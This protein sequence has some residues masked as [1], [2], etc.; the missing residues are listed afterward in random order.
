MRTP[1]TGSASSGAA[2]GQILSRRRV[3]EHVERADPD[4]RIGIGEARTGEAEIGRIE[5][6]RELGEQ[7]GAVETRRRRIGCRR[8]EQGAG[9]GALA[10]GVVEG[11][12]VVLEALAVGSVPAL[13]RLCRPFRRLVLVTVVAGVR[14]SEP[15]GEIGPRNAQRVV[16]ARVDDHVGAGRHVA[17]GAADGRIDA[18]VP[19]VRGDSVFLRRVALQTDAVAGEFQP[20][21]VRIVAVAAG[22]ALGEHLA[23]L[24]RAVIVDFI[25]HLPVGEIEAAGERRDDMRVRQPLAGDPILRDRPAAGVAEAAGLDLLAQDRRRR[26]APGVA[27]RSVDRPAG[28]LALVEIDD[29]AF[30]VAGLV[31]RAPA[32]MGVRPGDMR[33]ALAVAGLAADADL[34]PCGGEGVLC[35]VVVLAHAGRVAFGAHEVPVLVEP[36]PV[37]DVVMA[38]RLVRIERKPALPA[39]VLRPAVPGDGERLQAPIGKSDQ[40][41]L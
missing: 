32:G 18:R 40:I 8:R 35:R 38:D 29:Q 6:G 22:D 9:A 30:G 3:F 31:V 4:H 12:G 10:P 41:L 23:L 19:V 2:I 28:V 7:A 11:F 1:R 17:G 27:G 13:N 20:G 5:I 16:V 26:G 25:L 15:D 21:T 39:L 34:G 37:Q 24:E 14:R 33:R 36:G